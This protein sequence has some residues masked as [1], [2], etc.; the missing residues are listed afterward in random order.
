MTQYKIVL[1]G[2][3]LE[4]ITIEANSP[5]EAVELV[6]VQLNTS[7]ISGDIEIIG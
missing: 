7:D 2:E 3:G 4:E 6:K 1:S 5:E